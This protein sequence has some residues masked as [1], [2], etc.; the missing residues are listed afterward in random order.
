MAER[1]RGA[2]EWERGKE[3]VRAIEMSRKGRGESLEGKH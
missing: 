2:R 3:Q 1:E